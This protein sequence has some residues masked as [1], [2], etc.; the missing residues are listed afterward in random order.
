MFD[1]YQKKIAVIICYFGEWPWYFDYYIHSCSFNPTVDFFIITDNV[2][3]KALS[4]NVYFVKKSLKDIKILASKKLGFEVALDY[5]YKICDFRPAYGLIFSDITKKYDFWGQSD[6][7]VIYGN[8]RSFMTDEVLHD[9]DFISTRHDYT[10]GAFALY[11]NTSLINNLFKKSKDYVKVFSSSE[12]FCFDECNYIHSLLEDGSRTIFD[13]E[14]NIESFTHVVKRA[15]IDNQI[16]AYFDFILIEGTPGN[17]K[18][19]NGRIIYKK[20]FE[21]ILYHLIKLKIV[22]NPKNTPKEIPDKYSISSKRIYF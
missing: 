11:R 10:T 2:Y 20:Y 1:T 8:I 12:H 7:D 21:A 17:I 5:A 19:D 14:T 16:R 18:F 6:I 4:K 9:Y 22:F 15:E 13:V 3:S